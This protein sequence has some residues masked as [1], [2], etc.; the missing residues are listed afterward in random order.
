M[1]ISVDIVALGLFVLTNIGI[2]CYM[3]GFIKAHLLS[4]EKRVTN[5]EVKLNG[6]N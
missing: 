3:V 1:A 2:S 6:R 4:L 5:L